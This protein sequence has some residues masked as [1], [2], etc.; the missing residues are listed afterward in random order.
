MFKIPIFSKWTLDS[1]NL[2]VPILYF[3]LLQVG[4]QQ[5]FHLKGQHGVID[6]KC[7]SCRFTEFAFYQG[8][9]SVREGEGDPQQGEQRPRGIHYVVV[10]KMTNRE[11]KLVEG[12]KGGG[13]REKKTREKKPPKK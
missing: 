3:R 2:L 13:G 4:V 5:E 6:V 7:K 11:N 8:E 9:N 10:V 12:K 1:L